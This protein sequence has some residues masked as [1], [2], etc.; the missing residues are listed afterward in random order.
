M[1]HDGTL[2]LYLSHQEPSGLAAQAN[3]LPEPDGEFYLII[4]AY[5]PDRTILDDSY[6]FPDVIR[7][8]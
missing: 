8:Q 2:T 3:W 1:F 7:K 6:R 4:R 5:V